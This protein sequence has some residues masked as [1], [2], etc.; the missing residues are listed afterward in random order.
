MLKWPQIP[1]PVQD[2]ET[3]LEPLKAIKQI[4]EMII[5][6]RGGAPVPMARTFI[7][8]IKPGASNS[9][10]TVRELQAGD[11]WINTGNNAKLNY[12]DAG[13]QVWIPTT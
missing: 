6:Q 12:W 3:H 11:L 1:E 7:T 2:P 4:V 13:T 9:P 5:G 10:Y 8:V